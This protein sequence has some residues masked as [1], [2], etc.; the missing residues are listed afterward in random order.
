MSLQTAQN[1]VASYLKSRGYAIDATFKVPI[2]ELLNRVKEYAEPEHRELFKGPAM[3]NAAFVK[4]VSDALGG[5]DVSTGLNR[6]GNPDSVGIRTED[7]GFVEGV[8]AACESAVGPNRKMSMDPL[9]GTITHSFVHGEDHTCPA[10]IVY[11]AIAAFHGRAEGAPED[12]KRPLAVRAIKGYLAKNH[13]VPKKGSK[14]IL[15]GIGM[16]ASA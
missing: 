15:S 8:L 1:V 13:I 16:N 14:G 6:S 3:D 11:G 2:R 7:D 9:T 5:A 12:L 4:L 10:S